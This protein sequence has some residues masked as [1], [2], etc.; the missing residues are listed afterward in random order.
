LSSFHTSAAFIIMV[1]SSDD[2][3]ALTQSEKPSDAN[4]SI[5]GDTDELAMAPAEVSK[6]P[7]TTASRGYSSK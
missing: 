6:K 7:T 2:E 5:D 1:S 4:N 3:E